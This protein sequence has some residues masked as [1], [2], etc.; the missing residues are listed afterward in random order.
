M[1]GWHN[2]YARECM[3]K[4]PGA[5]RPGALLAVALPHSMRMREHQRG[6]E[7]GPALRLGY[8][9]NGAY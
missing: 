3:L 7:L 6:R 5:G 8:R 9:K 2:T 4:G 1:I